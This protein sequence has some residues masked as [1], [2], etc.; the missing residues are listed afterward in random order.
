MFDQRRNK[1]LGAKKVI[2]LVPYAICQVIDLNQGGISFR[3]LEKH[4]FPD[5]LSIGIYDITGLSMEQLQVQKVWEKRVNSPNSPA[6]FLM[7]VG[8][9]FKNLSIAQESHLR[10]YLQQLEEVDQ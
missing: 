9:E 7:A 6:S 3:C 4:E 1:R 5:E 2:V 10:F 8:W